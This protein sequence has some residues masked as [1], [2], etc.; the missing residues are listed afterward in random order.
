M[1]WCITLLLVLQGTGEP[2]LLLSCAVFYAVRSAVQSARADAG[3]PSEFDFDSPATVR[4]ILLACGTPWLLIVCSHT[5]WQCVIIDRW[6]P[7]SANI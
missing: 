4:N 3:L 7:F 5:R 2:P 6:L 1:L